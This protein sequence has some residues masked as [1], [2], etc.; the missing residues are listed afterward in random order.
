MPSFR[1]PDDLAAR[2]LRRR[3]AKACVELYRIPGEDVAGTLERRER[4]PQRA[5][6]LL[7]DAF[8]RP[9]VGAMDRSDYARLA[10]Q[11]NLV[12]ANAENLAGDAL[13]VIGG[14]IDRK[15]RDLFRRHLLHALNPHLFLWCIHWDRIDHARPGKGRYAI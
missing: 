9:A 13:R 1:L 3:S 8:G 5:L 2:Q 14:E 7:A 10:K 15:R 12:V 4:R 11:E 6:E